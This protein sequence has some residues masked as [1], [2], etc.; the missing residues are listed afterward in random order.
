M[1]L[2]L[3]GTGTFVYIVISTLI[4]VHLQVLLTR[5]CTLMLRNLRVVI[6]AQVAQWI[7]AALKTSRALVQILTETHGPL[8]LAPTPSRYCGHLHYAE[9]SQQWPQVCPPLQCTECHMTLY[10]MMQLNSVPMRAT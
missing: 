10:H 3:P 8:C 5:V 6:C 7:H 1:I 9:T 2:I 4:I